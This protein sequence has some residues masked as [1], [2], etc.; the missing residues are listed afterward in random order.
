[1]SRLREY[2]SDPSMKTMYDMVRA[3]GAVRPISLDITTTRRCCTG[4][5]RSCDSCFDTWEHFSWIM[6]NMRKHL[7]SRREFADWLTTMF[8]FYVVNRLVDFDAG[9]EILRGRLAL[10]A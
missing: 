7:G 10:D 1:M 5:Q 8:A 4:I 6:I 2:L 9:L 3:A